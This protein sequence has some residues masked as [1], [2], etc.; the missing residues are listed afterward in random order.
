MLPALTVELNIKIMCNAFIIHI[1]HRF[2]KQ[3]LR[4]AKS[5]NG[6]SVG[7]GD[8][9]SMKDIHCTFRGLL[10]WVEFEVSSLTQFQWTD[11]FRSNTLLVLPWII[12]D[13]RLP[14]R[15]MSF[16]MINKVN[17]SV[18]TQWTLIDPSVVVGPSVR[19]SRWTVLCYIYS[20]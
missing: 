9:L 20:S 10:W 7:E 17:G 5:Y 2:K 19:P 6:W 3:V 16:P 11:S 13:M 18:T 1:I 8:S 14:Q 4:G 15:K 12:P